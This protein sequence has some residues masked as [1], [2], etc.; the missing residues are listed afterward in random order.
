MEEEHRTN[1]CKMVE[2]F[3]FPCLHCV[4]FEVRLLCHDLPFF[5]GGYKR[6]SS[7]A[8]GKETGRSKAPSIHISG[9]LL[10]SGWWRVQECRWGFL[11]LWVFH[12]RSWS[13]LL[14]RVTDRV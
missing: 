2:V 9:L 1:G 4:G 6:S 14:S 13:W 10:V 11:R 3:V 8:E 12:K 5:F 7:G